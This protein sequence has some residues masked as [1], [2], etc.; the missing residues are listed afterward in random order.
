[1]TQQ[2]PQTTFD[3]NSEVLHTEYVMAN[4]SAEP[5]FEMDDELIFD[6]ALATMQV[7]VSATTG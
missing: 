7:S 5:I 4:A 2:N 1:M 6:S 3:V